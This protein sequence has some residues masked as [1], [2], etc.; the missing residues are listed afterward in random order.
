MSELK[1]SSP[2]A[3]IESLKGY[4]CVELIDFIKEMGANIN[5]IKPRLSFILEV[6]SLLPRDGNL[7]VVG[8]KVLLSAKLLEL[9][10]YSLA[11]A[12]GDWYSENAILRLAGGSPETVKKY[13]TS[14]SEDL[15]DIKNRRPYSINQNKI[16][17]Y[18]SS[19][20]LRRYQNSRNKYSD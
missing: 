5:I 17:I 7:I 15:T 6:E 18:Y 16:G 13:L 8:K 11:M 20:V 4:G 1:P 9:L 12:P 14:L 2:E 10:K 19:E 3:Y